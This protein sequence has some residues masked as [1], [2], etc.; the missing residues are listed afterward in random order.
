MSE[1]ALSVSR[2]ADP[3]VR[4]S[5]AVSAARI[6]AAADQAGTQQIIASLENIIA[7]TQKLGYF[8]I[9]LEARLAL[10]EVEMKSGAITRGR[11]HLQALRRDASQRGFKVLAGQAAAAAA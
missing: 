4:L 9:E 3:H 5:V 6:R 7:E 10:G 8:G 1:R 11:A 2:Q